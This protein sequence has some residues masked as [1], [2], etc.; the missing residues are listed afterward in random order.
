MLMLVCDGLKGLPDAAN[1]VWE[2]TIVQTYI[3]TAVSEA[4]AWTR[5]PSSPGN[6]RSATRLS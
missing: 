3:Y 2:K 5:S 4:A 1:A 6:G